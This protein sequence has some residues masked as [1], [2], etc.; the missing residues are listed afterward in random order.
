MLLLLLLLK[1]YYYVPVIQPN[2]SIMTFT[3]GK[4]FNSHLCDQSQ[5]VPTGI[6]NSMRGKIWANR[7]PSPKKSRHDNCIIKWYWFYHTSVV[8]A[9]YPLFTLK[10]LFNYL[11]LFCHKFQ[12]SSLYIAWFIVWSN[13]H[14]ANN[15]MCLKS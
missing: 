15:E 8:Y 2:W 5:A 11:S 12:F 9:I 6:W 10:I 3:V 14:N 1:I 13:L 7:T 4:R